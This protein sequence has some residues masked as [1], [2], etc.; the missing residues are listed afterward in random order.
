MKR[1]TS[2]FL[3]GLA[4]AAAGALLV[5]ACVTRP[6]GTAVPA[7]ASRV[8]PV[9]VT[10]ADEIV[11]HAV[12]LLGV[13]Y[14]FGGDDPARGFDCSGFVRYVFQTVRGQTLPRQSRDIGRIGA[15]VAFDA[16][17]IGDLVFFNTLGAA[18]SHVAIYVGDGRFVHAPAL[19]GVVRI[20]SMEEPYWRRRF[21]GARRIPAAEALFSAPA[22]MQ[23]PAPA[24]RESGR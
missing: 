12:G 22:P 15:P 6:G 11:L 9:A 24:E 7:A 10:D 19:R 13:A 8:T 1:L 2:A 21:D 18:F 16:L 17:A 23:A 4:F 5:T 20:E 3:P 14:R